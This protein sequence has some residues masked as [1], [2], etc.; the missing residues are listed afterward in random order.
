VADN[1]IPADFV[2]TH[3]TIELTSQNSVVPGVTNTGVGQGKRVE[4][5]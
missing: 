3:P 4:D 2:N 5:M 1:D